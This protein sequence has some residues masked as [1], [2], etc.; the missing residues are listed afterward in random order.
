MR[1]PQTESIEIKLP[2]QGRIGHLNVPRKLRG[3]T[4]RLEVLWGEIVHEDERPHRKAR[5]KNWF[6]IAATRIHTEHSNWAKSD[7]GVIDPEEWPIGHVIPVQVFI[8]DKDL[9]IYLARMNWHRYS[10]ATG[11]RFKTKKPAIEL[12]RPRAYQ[13]LKALFKA[14]EMAHRASEELVRLL[15]SMMIP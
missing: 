3:K 11:K 4:L 15:S 5:F 10:G 2:L 6:S 1:A 8:E 14:R 7:D 9:G 12:R 13:T